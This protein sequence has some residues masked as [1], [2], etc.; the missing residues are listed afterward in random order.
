[1]N[2]FKN[3]KNY[4]TSSSPVTANVTE[5]NNI[6][7]SQ[8]QQKTTPA[9][10][11]VRKNSIDLITTQKSNIE[12]IE[13]ESIQSNVLKRTS[14]SRPKFLRSKSIEERSFKLKTNKVTND[15]NEP[16]GNELFKLLEIKLDKLIDH[17]KPTESSEHLAIPSLTIR[18]NDNDNYPLILTSPAYFE[19]SDTSANTYYKL[20][21]HAKSSLNK[22]VLIYNKLEEKISLFDYEIGSVKSNGYRSILASFEA[23]CKRLL[24][25]VSDLN[26]KK[27]S[28][29]FQLKLNTTLPVNTGLKE[30][31]AWVKLIDKFEIILQTAIDMQTISLSKLKNTNN[32]NDDED[33]VPSLFINSKEMNS[34]NIEVN[35]F[36][37]GSVYQDSFFGRSC[38]FQFCD[39]LQ[40]PLTGCAV[41]LASYNDGY[42]AYSNNKENTSTLIQSTSSSPTS[43][44]NTHSSMTSL[45]SQATL[46]KSLFSGTKY[47]LDPEL[48]AKKV[49][50]VI[51]D[52]NVEF[53]K[54]FWQL[55]ETSIVQMGSNLITPQLAV[56]VLKKIPLSMPLKLP[57]VL[58]GHKSAQLIDENEDFVYINP[59]QG[60]NSNETVQIRLLS[61]E[62]RIGM[63]EL[64]N[65]KLIESPSSFINIS[66][67]LNNFQTNIPN[68]PYLVLHV[69]GGGFIAHSS[70]SHEVCFYYFFL[71]TIITEN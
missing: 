15:M 17:F 25:V 61:S 48:R 29:L 13:T 42:E 64:N 65:I 33:H 40:I 22:C 30:L 14:T 39:S 70:K 44:T 71:L 62:M 37:L 6:N 1:M 26:D 41:A 56:N 60:S 28:F 58:N 54:S 18:E 43:P 59:P 57:R 63:Q 45:N 19:T 34:S 49:S 50:R 11:S 69:H 4:L 52:A 8:Q 24:S 23:C 20:I 46:F 66:T 35:L 7:S 9:I 67:S 10:F 68:S 21:A 53:C 51:K 27:T 32:S 3:L 47:I 16:N 12:E 31:Q 5:S 36:Y 38:G 55:T 2:R